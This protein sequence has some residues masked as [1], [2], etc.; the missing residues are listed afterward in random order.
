MGGKE[1]SI[2]MYDIHIECIVENTN[3]CVLESYQGSYQYVMYLGI[4]ELTYNSQ[5]LIYFFVTFSS[6]D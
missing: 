6:R 5:V 4:L 2:Y 3:E 1:E